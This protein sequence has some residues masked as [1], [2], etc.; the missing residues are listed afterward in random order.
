MKLPKWFLLILRSRLLW[1]GE[2]NG[3]HPAPEEVLP[4]IFLGCEFQRPKS[5]ENQMPKHDQSHVYRW[6]ERT[7][8][9]LILNTILDILHSLDKSLVDAARSEN[10][11]KGCLWT[12]GHIDSALAIAAGA[13]SGLIDELKSEHIRR[14]QSNEEQAH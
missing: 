11:C 1:R 4:P 2:L 5:K 7:Q 10:W 6:I 3:K 8:A 14:E 9:L 13:I 12:A